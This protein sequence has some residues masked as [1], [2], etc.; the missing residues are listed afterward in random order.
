MPI[1]LTPHL[2]RAERRLQSWPV[3][4]GITAA[5]E[6]TTVLDADALQL[7]ATR[8]DQQLTQQLLVNDLAY[9]PDITWEMQRVE[10]NAQEQLLNPPPV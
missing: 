3:V 1:D 9:A 7:T 6:E 8:G 5:W 2:E 10:L 4:F